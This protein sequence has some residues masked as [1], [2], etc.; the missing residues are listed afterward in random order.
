MSIIGSNILAGASGQATGYNLNNSLRYRGS[1]SANL[2]RTPASATNR[3]TWTWSAWIKRGTIGTQQGLFIGNYDGNDNSTCLL[4]D[5]GDQLIFFNRLLTVSNGNIY[6]TQ[7][8]RDT[9]AWY[10]IVVAMDTTQ[11]T[12][13][14]RYKLYINGIQVTSFAIETYP[15][16]NTTMYIN[17]NVQHNIGFRRDGATNYYFD[18]YMAEVNF[19]DGQQL[20][21]S[22]FG[23]TSTTTGSWIPKKYTSTYGT[24]GYYLNFSDI[25]QTV[26]S[27]VGLGKDFSGNANYWVTN[28]ISTTAGVTYDAM[29]DVPTNTSA[30]VG[31]Y[32]TLN[33]LNPF[34]TYVT[35]SNA[36][37]TA[38]GNT[39]VNTD[40]VYSTMGSLSTSIYWEYTC[41]TVGSSY[42]R[43]G[44]ITIFPT[45]GGGVPGEAPLGG[46]GWRQDGYLTQ[47]ANYGVL[48]TFTTNDVLGFALNP[49]AGTCALYKN[50]SLVYTVTGLS[51][52]STFFPATA[53]YNGSV[54][55]YNFGQ[56]PFSYTPPSGFVALNTFNLPSSTIPQGNKYMDATTYTGTGATATITNA[57]SFKPDLVWVKCRSHGTGHLLEDTVRGVLQYIG[58]E[59]TGAEST[60]AGSITSFNSNGFSVGTQTGTNSS[61]RTFVGWQWQAGQGTNTSNT[62]GSITSTVSVSTTAGF[63]VVTYI[64]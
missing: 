15:T 63:S 52:T 4:F 16:Q 46:F 9:S 36:N 34:K 39:A 42:G 29:L 51:T 54:G 1:N 19:V 22:S 35:L 47:I 50:G 25:A 44:A 3:T 8:F 20:T 49:T 11:A 43:T 40:T 37:L 12:A 38:T 31:N 48:P 28:N 57:A 58:S 13:A 53:E 18:G 23:E 41:V 27:N 59:S 32:P 33:P 24:N 21:P 55:A 62:S 2:Q 14:N 30:T 61:G 60:L 56:R 6:T 17:S 5:G 64:F 10:H 45:A 26:S 7:V